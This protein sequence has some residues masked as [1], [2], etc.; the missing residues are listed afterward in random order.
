MCK[1]CKNFSRMEEDD[2]Q[3]DIEFWKSRERF[4]NGGVVL[5]DERYK[6]KRKKGSWNKEEYLKELNKKT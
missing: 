4:L 2:K 6:V 3:A 5:V 1:K